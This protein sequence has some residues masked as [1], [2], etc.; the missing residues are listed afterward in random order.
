M[1]ASARTRIALLASLLIL[2]GCAQRRLTHEP[3]LVSAWDRSQPFPADSP[4]PQIALVIHPRYLEYGKPTEPGVAKWW[5]KH[6]VRH[7]VDDV[8][9]EFPFLRQARP[10]D[11]EAPYRL[12]IEATHAIRGNKTLHWFSGATYG[13]IP[14]KATGVIELDAVVAQGVQALKSYTATGSYAITRQ[15]LL[16]LLPMKWGY[17]VP[18]ATMEDTFRDLFL[19]IQRDAPTLFPETS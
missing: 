15:A 13:L 1:A 4:S 10:T 3:G 11:V 8:I 17:K 14:E 9:G 2:T 16:M 18:A 6:K 19:Q 5:S 7:Q 12:E